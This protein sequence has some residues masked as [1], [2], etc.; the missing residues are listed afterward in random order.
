MGTLGRI[1]LAL[2]IGAAVVVGFGAA[3]AGLFLLWRTYPT[4]WPE[5][6]QHFQALAGAFVALFAA[7]LGIVGVVLTIRT[8]RLNVDRQ[9]DAQRKEQGRARGLSRRQVAA[10]FIGEITVLVEELQHEMVRPALTTALRAVEGGSGPVPVT[11]VR[12]GG[13]LGRYFDSNP[14]NVGLFPNPVPEN[15]TR[16][17]SRF[18]AIELDL[19]RYSEFA[20]AVARALSSPHGEPVSGGMTPEQVIYLLRTVLKHIEFCLGFGSA[21]IKDLELIRDAPLGC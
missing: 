14:G 1:A 3:P 16:F 4:A 9:L 19:D 20:E 10:A 15:L 18:E 21:L 6:L 11:T 12:M 2:V 17:Y 13:K 8:Q 5:E 7:S